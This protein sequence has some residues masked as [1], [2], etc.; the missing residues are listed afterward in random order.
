M[1]L[2]DHIGTRLEGR[3]LHNRGTQS[4]KLCKWQWVIGTT[5]S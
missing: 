5:G 1:T 3:Y 4:A 2:H